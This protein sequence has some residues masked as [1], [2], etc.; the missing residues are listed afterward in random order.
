MATRTDL[1]AALQAAILGQVRR[2]PRPVIVIAGDL[3]VTDDEVR[4]AVNAMVDAGALEDYGSANNWGYKMRSTSVRAYGLPG[5]ANTGDDDID[6]I[7]RAQR[8]PSKR[9]GS[10]VIAPQPYATGYR[11]GNV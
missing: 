7:E 3:R 2:G 8:R 9:K 6:E 4:K 11:W 10:G 1:D 5:L